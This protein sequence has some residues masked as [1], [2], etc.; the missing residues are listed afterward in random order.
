MKEQELKFLK[1]K[2]DEI[3]LGI[4]KSTHAAKSGHPGG[5]LSIVDVLTYLYFH[6]MNID[7][8]NPSDENRDRL[9][10]S[11]GHAA[12]GLY[13]TL[14]HRGYFSTDELLKLRKPEAMLQGHPDMKGTP[15]VD[16]S[17]GSLGQGVSAACGI[18]LFGKLNQKNYNVYAILG[19]GE[20]EEGQVWEAAMFAGQKKLSNL[21]VIV[22]HNGMQIDGTLKEVN[23]PEPLDEKF[24]AFGFNVVRLDDAHDFDKI[25][26]TLSAFDKE[27]DKPTAIIMESIKGKGVS[28]ME[29]QVSWHGK[30]PNDEQLEIAVKE[31]EA[32][33]EKEAK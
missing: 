14:A 3:R 27:N 11:K 18:A 28:F 25:D 30:A 2:A 29:R 12:P 10:L 24:E 20:C 8:T 13:S 22:D 9:I 26:I 19:D 15:G 7:P 33:L 23:S 4:V 16:M 21:C 1:Q 31:I 5:S 32:R 17:T 6:K